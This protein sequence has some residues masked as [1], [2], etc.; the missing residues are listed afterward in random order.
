MLLNYLHCLCQQDKKKRDLKSGNTGGMS[1]R[2]IFTFNPSILAEN[3]NEDDE[4]GADFDLNMREK[5]EDDGV[6]VSWLIEGKVKLNF[7]PI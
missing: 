5:E 7:L 1:G 6:K 2:D 3:G 4:E